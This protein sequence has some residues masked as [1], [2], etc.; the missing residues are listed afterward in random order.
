MNSSCSCGT[1]LCGFR[2]I[3]GL[4][5]SSPSCLQRGRCIVEVRQV[6]TLAL[7]VGLLQQTLVHKLLCESCLVLWPGKT[8]HFA[9]EL[10]VVALQASTVTLGQVGASETREAVCTPDLCADAHFVCAAGNGG[11]HGAD[12]A[13]EKETD[14]FRVAFV[15]MLDARLQSDGSGRRIG[16]PVFTPW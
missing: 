13:L 14:D 4:C 1:Y 5:R 11:V 3:I 10:D 7:V 6:P 12:H 15:R 2:T 16:S 8:W 9:I